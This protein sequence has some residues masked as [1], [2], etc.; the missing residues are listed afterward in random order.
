M[1]RKRFQ[2][3][4]SRLG[5]YPFIWLVY[6]ILPIFNIRSETG[7]K[8][9]LGYALIALFV[10]TYRQLYWATST[11]ST[12]LGI[13]MLIIVIMSVFY[14]PY[15]LYM[16]FF[17]A[18]FIGYFTEKRRFNIAMIVFAAV[19][20]LP[21]VFLRN[22]LDGTDLL[23]ILP[24]YLIM[25]ISPFGIRSMNQR[26]NLEKELDQANAQIKELIKREERMRI[27]RDLHDTLGHTLS[28]ITLKSQLVEKLA[29]KDPQRAQ[30]EA[31][32]I[33]RTSRAALR[34]VRELVSDMR[35]ITVAEELAGAGEILKSAD[36]ALEVEGDANL[37]GV[38]DL[39][40]N[41]LSL[42]IKEAMTNIVKHSQAEHCLIRIGVT[43]ADVRV[44]IEDDG[45]GLKHEGDESLQGN[46]LKGMAE[47]LSLIEGSLRLSPGKKGGTR[48]LVTVPLIVK[49]RKEG[50]TA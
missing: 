4:P 25:M 29:L 31:G 19:E 41:I 45:V 32:E 30:F 44:D 7:V 42:C 8:L 36:I 10:V 22:Q 24:F 34:Q 12:W 50:E 15:N 3:F 14:N 39:T 46:G 49:E 16:G 38:S 47:R 18:N 11:F 48:L 2:L 40:Q 5:F 33:Q 43:D 37:E 6:I 13:Q 26:Q 1:T 28:L 35:A 17:T 23:F 9:F 27:A 21:L 20:L